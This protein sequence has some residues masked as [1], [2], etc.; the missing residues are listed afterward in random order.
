[1]QCECDAGSN[2]SR[3]CG[4]CCDGCFDVA[5]VAAVVE[6]LRNRVWEMVLLHGTQS[7][8][9]D[10]FKRKPTWKDLDSIDFPGLAVAPGVALKYVCDQPCYGFLRLYLQ[11]AIPLPFLAQN[12]PAHS[13][14]SHNIRSDSQRIDLGSTTHHHRH[15][16]RRAAIPHLLPPIP[17]PRRQPRTTPLSSMHVVIPRSAAEYGAPISS[18]SSTLSL[19]PAKVFC[20]EKLRDFIVIFS[21]VWIF[22]IITMVIRK[23]YRIRFT[24]R[25]RLRIIRRRPNR[26]RQR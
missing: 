17:L 3:C 19:T 8:V 9:T 13:P 24:G 14:S 6:D 22:I 23:L 11:P 5:V 2:F 4:R 10:T 26:N 16:G 20:C 21:P 15:R 18:F 1:M 25:V 12:L 7:Y